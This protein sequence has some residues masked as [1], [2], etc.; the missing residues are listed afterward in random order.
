MTWTP[1]DFILNGDYCSV[2]EIYRAVE[3]LRSALGADDLVLLTFDSRTILRSLC[4]S[5]STTPLGKA[6]EEGFRQR[7]FS[8]GQDYLALDRSMTT[9]AQLL[10]TLSRYPTFS[11]LNDTP[12]PS[13]WIL[14]NDV[15]S[16]SDRTLRIAVLGRSASWG[17]SNA[18]D[19][20]PAEGATKLQIMVNGTAIAGVYRDNQI[21]KAIN[22]IRVHGADGLSSPG[23]NEQAIGQLLD[24]LREAVAGDGLAWYETSR[25]DQTLYLRFVSCRAGLH[26][27]NPISLGEKTVASIEAADRNQPV[28]ITPDLATLQSRWHNVEHSLSST[29]EAGGAAVDELAMPVPLTP[30]GQGSLPAGVLS[31]AKRRSGKEGA[32]FGPY[33]MALVR[34]AA[35]RISAVRLEELLADTSEA[36]HSLLVRVTRTV[37]PHLRDELL[38]ELRAPGAGRSAAIYDV[39][40]ARP[41]I[42]DIVKLLARLTA[43]DTVTFRAL[44]VHE[45][46]TADAAF[47]MQRVAAYPPHVLGDEASIIPLSED[48][49][50]SW[51]AK[52]GQTCYLANVGNPA[53]Y[54]SYP[55]LH[56]ALSVRPSRSELCL[57]VFVDDRLAGTLN[58][59]SEYRDAFAGVIPLVEAFAAQVALVLRWVRWAIATS[60]LSLASGLHRRAHEMLQ[61]LDSLSGVAAELPSTDREEVLNITARLSNALVGDEVQSEEPATAKP[62]AAIFNEV[63]EL[64]EVRFIEPYLQEC[65]SLISSGSVG[66]VRAALTDA[67]AS[68]QRHMSREP[69]SRLVVR[70][71]R[72]RYGGVD[73]VDLVVRHQTSRLVPEGLSKRL[74]R[75]PIA[76]PG[77]KLQR[78][79]LGSYTAGYLLRSV[80]GD[81]FLR[82]LGPRSVE[83]VLSIP[84]VG[85]GA[86]D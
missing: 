83:I 84:E 6:I 17:T 77:S 66:A 35:I 31:V 76:L 26:P 71:W 44:T 33:D 73:Y 23:K 29:W 19:V 10:S 30:L 58:L 11:R 64:L 42:A 53:T 47:C 13:N 24:I 61:D 46:A 43:A 15:G 3:S 39:E 68:A 54:S 59:E 25:S 86:I 37:D 38:T 60:T 9:A 28:L 82:R 34:N 50:H 74:F 56:K 7:P 63:V 5:T 70:C 2:D 12:P 18:V 41:H 85:G 67:L 20:I 14:L 45:S 78:P 65:T 69:G 8:R 79:H 16:P 72:R 40:C 36:H 57:P 32:G 4:L 27:I 80:G 21:T 55:G 1:D 51:V 48:S 62:L 75:V 81:A 52:T 22:G 49:V